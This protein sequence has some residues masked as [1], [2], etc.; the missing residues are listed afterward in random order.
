MIQDVE[1]QPPKQMNAVTHRSETV[2]N[3]QHQQDETNVVGDRRQMRRNVEEQSK[4]QAPDI[5]HSS[6]IKGNSIKGK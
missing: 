1:E 3:D 4:D 5:C 6:Q 2:Q